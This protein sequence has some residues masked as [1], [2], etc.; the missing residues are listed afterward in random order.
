MA[1]GLFEKKGHLVDF[2]AQRNVDRMWP[3]VDL[4]LNGM[5]REW[6]RAMDDVSV[7]IGTTDGEQ[8]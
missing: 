8:Q 2:L 3:L 5:D 7:P 4:W 6:Q 1:T